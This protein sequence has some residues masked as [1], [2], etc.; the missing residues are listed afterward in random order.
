M[1]GAEAL[2]I[3][4][5][6]TKEHAVALAGTSYHGLKIVGFEREERVPM[7]LSER[8]SN[9]NANK[10][11]RY[12]I[13]IVQIVAVGKEN[14]ALTTLPDVVQL[15]LSERAEII[16]QELFVGEAEK[17]PEFLESLQMKENID[18]FVIVCPNFPGSFRYQLHASKQLRTYLQKIA[19][20]MAQMV[21]R[22]ISSQESPSAALFEI[23]IGYIGNSFTVFLP[24]NGVKSGLSSVTTLLRATVRSRQSNS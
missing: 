16:T 18:I 11:S 17:L 2:L 10:K 7:Q 5:R 24:S 3:L 4:P 14:Y 22:A 15:A 8:F 19:D 1:L 20:P 23:V 6:A 9:S 13:G 21:R 12:H